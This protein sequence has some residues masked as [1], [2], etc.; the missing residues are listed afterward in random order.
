MRRIWE[1]IVALA[2]FGAIIWNALM[3]EA[4]FGGALPG[5]S[6]ALLA[7]TVSWWFAESDRR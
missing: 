3:G 1:F 7:I 5:V 2:V 6:L 4:L